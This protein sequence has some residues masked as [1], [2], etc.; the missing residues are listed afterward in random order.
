MRCHLYKAIPLSIG[1]L[2]AFALGG[3]GTFKP[4]VERTNAYLHFYKGGQ[5]IDT[6]VMDYRY[7]DTAAGKFTYHFAP[8]ECIRKPVTPV[9]AGV[10]PCQDGEIN[11]DHILRGGDSISVNLLYGF[12]CDFYE[13]ANTP[14]E[15]ARDFGSE[16]KGKITL[17]QDSPENRAGTRGEIALMASIFELGG[18]RKISFQADTVGDKSA[19]MVYYSEDVRESGQSLN[20]SNLPMYGPVS[21]SGKPV[22]MGLFV[23]EI[24]GPEVQATGSILRKL[25][26]LGSKA[27][28]P[29]SPVLGALSKVGDAFLQSQQDDSIVDYKMVFDGP[30]GI[31]PR[32]APLAAGLYVFT[33]LQNRSKVFDWKLHCLDASTGKIYELLKGQTGATCNETTGTLFT[34]ETYFTIQ[35]KRNEPALAQDVYQ[36]F[37]EFS[38]QDQETS[39]EPDGL[40]KSLTALQQGV[41]KVASFDRARSAIVHLKAPLATVR[42]QAQEALMDALCL[43]VG[44]DSGKELT[45]GSLSDEQVFYL[46]RRAELAGALKDPKAVKDTY[47]GTCNGRQTQWSSVEALFAAPDQPST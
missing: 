8:R 9:P 23:I 36:T 42:R 34:A 7:Y 1:C 35:V 17:C 46:L 37:Q 2:A 30:E 47:R 33:R 28:P 3:C 39:S 45:E 12:I 4:G 21:Y 10:S 24:D 43:G 32:T 41:S 22:Y 11:S 6:G 5:K 31:S 14:R 20:L 29:S 44:E 18:D 40:S 27:Y 19:R 26:D 13:A 16:T 38:A 25:A 15:L